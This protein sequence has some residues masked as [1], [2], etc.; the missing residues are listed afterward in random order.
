VFNRFFKYDENQEIILKESKEISKCEDKIESP[1][2][3][4]A[5]FR[6][7]RDT[8]WTGYVVHL[9]E[10]CNDNTVNL[11]TDVYT[12][13]ADVHD[14]KATEIIQSNLASKGLLPK[15]H[16][17][18]TG[19]VSIDHIVNS[20]KKFNIDI[21]G[22]LKRSVRWQNKL[23][24]AYTSKDFN[25]DWDN[26]RVQC[27]Q[28]KY[29]GSWK[30]HASNRIN[31][32]FRLKDCKYCSAKNLCTQSNKRNLNILQK[33]YSDKQ[34]EILELMQ[35]DDFK[36]EYSK[37]AGI[38]GTISQAVRRTDMR[39]SRYI[40]LQKTRLQE[41]LKASAMNLFRLAD[42]FSGKAREFTRESRFYQLRPITL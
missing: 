35:T 8:Q 3:M 2:D 10:T 28:G 6:T 30:E 26:N 18:D 24:G 42:W 15:K 34:N 38:E 36:N 17:V 22:K 31:V 7:K 21:V 33:E 11:V 1:Y 40:G 37:R 14:S 20:K 41:S 13:P 16:I 4:D 29:S 12:T 9:T 27:P 39:K 25:I 23:I 19:Y 32:A 5:R